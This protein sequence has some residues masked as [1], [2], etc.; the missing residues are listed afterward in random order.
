MLVYIP[1]FSQQSLNC[2]SDKQQCED[3]R[4]CP[5]K[6]AH[7][8]LFVGSAWASSREPGCVGPGKGPTQSPCSRAQNLPSNRHRAAGASHQAR[9]LW[10]GAA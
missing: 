5:G 9:P 7:P 4:T 8:A 2:C 1:G 10:G 6:G 3:S